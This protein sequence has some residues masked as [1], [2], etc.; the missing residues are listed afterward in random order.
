MS[1]NPY[2]LQK[3]P[4]LSSINRQLRRSISGKPLL[5]IFAK[6][7]CPHNQCW[8]SNLRKI[9]TDSILRQIIP[10]DKQQGLILVSYTDGNDTFPFL[11]GN[12]LKSETEIKKIIT[13]EL[14]LLFSKMTIPSPL[15]IYSYYFIHSQYYPPFYY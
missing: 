3:F 9:T 10:I 2:Q 1:I 11:R 5:K 7:P 6:Y 13:R 4:Y 15:K 8:F 12:N 14:N